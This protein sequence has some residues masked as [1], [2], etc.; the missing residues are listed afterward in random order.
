[1]CGIAG[2]LTSAK[3]PLNRDRLVSMGNAIAHR[4]P[5]A[6]GYYLSE[7][8]VGLAHRRLSIIDLTSGEQ[9]L[10]N[11]DKSIQIVFNGEIYN[12]LELQKSLKSRGHIF[13]TKSDTESIVHLYEEY[14]CD[15]V[16]H[17]RGMFAFA[18]WDSKK[19]KLLLARDRVGQKPLYFTVNQNQ[20][21]FASEIKSLLTQEGIDKTLNH[22]AIEDYLCYGFVPGSQSI[23]QNI[24]KLAPGTWMEFDRDTWSFRQETYWSLPSVEVKNFSESQW[25]EAIEDKL[26]ETVKAHQI[27]DVP[28]GSF[29]SGGLDSSLVTSILSQHADSPPQTFSIGFQEK[30]FSELEYA[31]L[32]SNQL[33]TKHTEEIV[34]AN[35]AQDLE[36]L[37]HFYDEPFAD[38]SAIPTMRVAKVASQYVKVALSGDGGDE[39]FGGYK[40]YAHDL[41]ESKLRNLFPSII[42]SQVIRRFALAYPKADWLPRP[43]RL[44]SALTNIASDA[45]NAYANT[46]SQC[47]SSLRKKLLSKKLSSELA[48]YKSSDHVTEHSMDGG[49]ALRGM[50]ATDIALMLPDDFL[51]KVDR[52]SMAHGLEARP[53]LVDHQF[54]ELAWQ[55]P[56]EFKIRDGETKWALKKIAENHLPSSI[57]YRPKQGFEIPIDAWLRGPLGQVFKETALA[58]DNLLA[59]YLN[60]DLVADLHRR[61]CNRT[62]KH[63]QL[64]WSILILGAWMKRYAS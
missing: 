34:T 58:T 44:Q 13:R 42:R 47:P 6:E 9:P 39:G 53:P 24:H 10:G 28:V 55:M 14:G 59:E 33:G 49:D 29:L 37:I 50:L 15:L 21:L 19:R 38:A 52:A 57:I 54:L 23:F 4:G 60:I 46:L 26:T 5:D 27:S 36:A 12:H 3:K 40:R 8:G 61:H 18:L 56:S 30:K 32:V 45:S 35:A 62:G 7:D 64:L 2:I 43:M 25:L 11:E 48:E 1:M 31:A 16:H 41:K 22:R 17:L 20:L 51:T 63:G